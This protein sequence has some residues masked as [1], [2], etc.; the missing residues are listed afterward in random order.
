MKIDQTVENHDDLLKVIDNIL[1]DA[2]LNREDLKGKVTFEGLDPIRPT[3][4]KVGAGGAAV[5]VANAIAS[6]LLYQ[7]KTGMGHSQPLA[8]HCT[9]LLHGKWQILCGSNEQVWRR[10]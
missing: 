2:G 1:E 3:V 5:G 7:E 4:L 6:A 10:Q 9:G 8:G